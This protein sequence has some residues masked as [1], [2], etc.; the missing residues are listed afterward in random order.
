MIQFIHTHTSVLFQVLFHLDYSKIAEFPVL[1]RSLLIILH[2]VVFPGGSDGKE[3]VCNAGD[4]ALIPG[5]GDP[6]EGNGNPLQ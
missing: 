1:Y 3:S 6:L 5:S 4:L 2:T